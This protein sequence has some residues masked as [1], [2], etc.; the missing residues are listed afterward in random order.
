MVR[1]SRRRLLAGVT[2]AALTGCVG[3][4]SAEESTTEAPTTTEETPEP[5]DSDG[6][7]S[8]SSTDSDEEPDEPALSQELVEAIDPFP[9]TVGEHTLK[10]ITVTSEGEDT[11]GGVPGGLGSPDR[12]GLEEGAVDVA[13][14][15]QYEQFAVTITS[16]VGSFDADAPEVPSMAGDV[17]VHRED[18]LLLIATKNEEGWE[19][20][21]DAATDA[22]DDDV[23]V[24]DD[25]A[26]EA[27]ARVSDRSFAVVIPDTDREVDIPELNIDE[28]ESL[29]VG[30]EQGEEL[31]SYR[32]VGVFES[33]SA[34]DEDA[35]E[36]FITD[37]GVNVEEGSVGSDGRLVTLSAERDITSSNTAGPNLYFTAEYDRESGTT[38][39]KFFADE[40]VET[41]QLTLYAEEQAI[42]DVWETDVLEGE[43]TVSIDADPL[44]ALHL[45]WTD[46]EEDEPV[47]ADRA[48]VRPQLTFDTE[49]DPGA[50]QARFTYTDELSIERIDRIQIHHREDGEMARGNSEG[51]PLSD[52]L[53]R[54]E[55]G[56]E[57]VVD[58]VQYGD[59]VSL[60]ATYE[61]ESGSQSSTIAAVRASPPG[62][63]YVED[64]A[65][66][67][68]VYVADSPQ[69]AENYE[70]LVDGEAQ[71]TQFA[72]EYETLDDGD[73]LAIDGEPGEE[74][75]VEW[76][77]EGG[78]ATVLETRLEPAASFELRREDDEI[79]LVYTADEPMA[80]DELRIESGTG[81]S[82]AF[83]EEYDTVTEGD[84]V[85]L[86][87]EGSDFVTVAW[88]APEQPMYIYHGSI[89]QLLHFEF[90]ESSG[91][92]TL[93]FEG[94]GEWPADEFEVSVGGETV[95]G[96]ADQYDTV[97]AGD[98][99]ELDAELG[100]DV[101]VT[102]SYSEQSRSV[103]SESI[104]PPFDF[105]FELSGSGEITIT[106]AVDVS[107]DP[108]ALNVA[109]F[110][111]EYVDRADVWAEEYETVESG[112][113]ITVE[114]PS[115]LDGVVIYHEEWE[116]REVFELDKQED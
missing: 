28:V 18:G 64:G 89:S 100:T 91:S 44:S 26:T 78:Q 20:G 57:I 56:A 33:E 58:D 39:V 37:S 106:S 10:Q 101:E 12:L 27:L 96:F 63:I 68:L 88:T 80:A 115:G 11:L 6:S 55:E 112:D 32:F 24:L 66:Q 110:G 114:Q 1:T 48:I 30:G 19:A 77:G 62:E 51:E 75:V 71:E 14:V 98:S 103:F 87:F 38:S 53:S 99:I 31:I 41:D 73:T 81:T 36:S 65:T 23:T 15:A 93:V 105:E 94:D 83:A 82:E 107:M 47:V 17:A 4:P 8:E 54:L 59:Q 34:V 92:P 61:W 9:D 116:A 40:Q 45:E 13:A 2:V 25:G 7:D 35:F 52:R 46:P 86:E 85:A 102:W 49:Y 70:V 95:A 69:P 109:F 5:D 108:S 16:V 42:E 111:E 72:D 3:D 113:S 50:E 97:T 43:H 84:A 76:Q 90:G 74:V 79:K 29:V 21:I 67:N 60:R 104:N 22:I